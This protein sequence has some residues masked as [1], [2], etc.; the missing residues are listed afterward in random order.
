MAINLTKVLFHYLD[1]HLWIY[2]SEMEYKEDLRI[3]YITNLLI[4]KKNIDQEIRNNF[5]RILQ[6]PTEIAV[7]MLWVNLI[8]VSLICIS[9]HLPAYPQHSNQRMLNTNSSNN[10]YYRI[11]QTT[12]KWT[13]WQITQIYQ[14][15]IITLWIRLI[16]LIWSNSWWPIKR[17]AIYLWKGYLLIRNNEVL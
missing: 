17:P 2:L 7:V 16:W 5:I 13:L 6:L 14:L 11:S 3:C 15:V 10:N 4:H 1:N 8:K 12:R 9:R